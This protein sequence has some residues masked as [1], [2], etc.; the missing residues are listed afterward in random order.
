L[1]DLPPVRAADRK[2]GQG[3]C[4][5][6]AV[7]GRRGSHWA[8]LLGKASRD[9]DR[10][11]PQQDCAKTSG[12]G[13]VPHSIGLL[14]AW[15]G[16]MFHFPMFVHHGRGDRDQCPPEYVGSQSRLQDNVK[17][18]SLFSITAVLFRNQKLGR[19]T[20]VQI[21][22][23]G[24]RHEEGLYIG[25]RE[26]VI[27]IN[28]EA[29]RDHPGEPVWSTFEEILNGMPDADANQGCGAR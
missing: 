27:I 14:D 6:Y 1:P 8:K 26:K 2:A 16:N 22:K 10:R 11:T 19:R 25:K 7:D 13:K 29:I 17:H 9:R 28:G 23:G 15:L 5:G 12:R 18:L 24:H 3:D 21:L 4:A 20:Q